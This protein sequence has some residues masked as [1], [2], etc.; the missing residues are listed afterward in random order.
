MQSSEPGSTRPYLI[1]AWHEW[2]SDNGFTP[3]INVAVDDFVIVPREYVND[4]EIVLNISYEATTALRMGNDCI[5]FK[6]RFAGIVREVVVPVDQVLAIF[7][8]ENSQGITFPKVEAAPKAANRPDEPQLQNT[9]D[10]AKQGTSRPFKGQA[11]SS[12]KPTAHP[13][14][15]RVK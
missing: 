6:A 13:T 12:S 2:C 8:R 10:N 5:E 11:R 14:L 3:Y 15:T 4:G 7:A 1:R 9:G